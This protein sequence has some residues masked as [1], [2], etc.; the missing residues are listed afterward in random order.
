MKNI[1]VQKKAAGRTVHDTDII[2]ILHF[3][4]GNFYELIIS[5]ID[6]GHPR[7]MVHELVGKQCIIT[8]YINL[9]TLGRVND[10]VNGNIPVKQT[11]MCIIIMIL[12]AEEETASTLRVKVPK[13]YTKPTLSQEA[14][15]VDG[16]CGFSNASF[17][18]I[19]GNL[20]QKLNL[21]TIA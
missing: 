11:A 4:Q 7:S 20:F 16:C 2:I 5:K 19:Y 3:F 13:Q 18:T 14:G 1:I 9:V 10:I 21:I 8:Y 6:S 12:P 17:N 15:Q